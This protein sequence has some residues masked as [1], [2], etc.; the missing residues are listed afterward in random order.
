VAP[1]FHAR[2]PRVERQP[3]IRLLARV[4]FLE[5]GSEYPGVEGTA[6]EPR[7]VAVPMLGSEEEGRDSSL[8]ADFPGQLVKL[9]GVHESNRLIVQ[10]RKNYGEDVAAVGEVREFA[11]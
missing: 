10:E 5:I 8:F 9:W 11:P 2:G 4:E 1:W 7:Q 6:F 3:V